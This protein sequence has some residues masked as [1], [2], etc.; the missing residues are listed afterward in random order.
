MLSFKSIEKC[1]T[2]LNNI[3]L[4]HMIQ[5]QRA[6]DSCEKYLNT[7]MLVPNDILS[8]DRKCEMMADAMLCYQRYDKA[9]LQFENVCRN[10]KIIDFRQNRR[11]RQK[12]I[13]VN[14]KT[15]EPYINE[16]NKCKKYFTA[17]IQNMNKLP[18]I[19]ISSK[20]ET[21]IV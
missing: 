8:N 4:P 13:T 5:L 10:M 6:K 9:I 19:D 12:N 7:M 15:I 14:Y 11:Q 16:M 1:N 18:D 2:Y 3:R 21:I 17:F 20:S